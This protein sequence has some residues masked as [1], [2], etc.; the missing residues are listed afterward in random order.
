VLL[1]LLLLLLLRSKRSREA[2]FNPRAH[3]VHTWPFQ[4]KEIEVDLWKG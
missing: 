4:A 3:N 2:R 1:L